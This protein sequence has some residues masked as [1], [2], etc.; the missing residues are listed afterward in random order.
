MPDP[1]PGDQNVAVEDANT[2]ADVVRE[3]L[4]STH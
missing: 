3:E 4:V 2:K 1:L